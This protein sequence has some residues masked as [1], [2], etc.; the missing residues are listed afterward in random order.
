MKRRCALAGLLLIVTDGVAADDYDP[1]GG[2]RLFYSEMSAA[3]QTVLTDSPATGNAEF[4]LDLATLELTW[5]LNYRDL[6]SPAVGIHIHG[7]AQPGTNA[8]PMLDLAPQSKESPLNGA[9]KVTE[10]QVQY[11]LQGWSYVSIHTSKFPEGEIRGKI[12]VR[13]PR[14][15]T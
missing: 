12:H 13:R 11:M 14:P 15:R 10:A 2:E 9:V 8:P 7:P 6:T 1:L 5:T 4:R 3:N